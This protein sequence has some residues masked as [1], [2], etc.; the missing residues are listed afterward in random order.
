MKAKTEVY[1]LND[2][3]RVKYRVDKRKLGPCYY[4][5]FRGP[6]GRVHEVSTKETNR[7]RATDAALAIIDQ[8]YQ[9]KAYFEDIGWDDAV[10]MM[11]E[12]M[13]GSNLRPHTISTYRWVVEAFRKVFPGVPG[14]CSVTP[15]MAEEYK[16]KRLKAGLSPHTV[17][18]D[19]N[20]LGTVFGKWW[21]EVCKI[22]PV[23][24]FE[25]VEPPKADKLD[26]RIVA[27]FEREA[28][29]TW[30]VERWDNWRLPSLFLAVKAAIGC[31]VHELAAMPTCRLLDGRLTFDAVQAK[32]RRTRRSKLPTTLFEELQSVAGSTY[33]FERFPEELRALLIRKGR[34]HHARCVKFPFDPSRLVNWLQDRLVEFRK[35]RPDIARFK[36][37]NFRGTAMSRAKEAGVSYDEAAIAFGCHPE[38]MRRHY[39]KVDETAVSDGV[40]DRI[41]GGE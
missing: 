4:A 10:A 5:Y 33:V 2:G 13:K 40:M 32:G 6:D 23:N 16:M 39:V 18:G 20:E 31:R 34:P 28:F 17:K 41:Q 36:L 27:P 7:R 22:T 26:P 15:A 11:V 9:P 24:P 12:H 29:E 3:R 38:T 14:P 25:N 19:L 8:T 21:C 35:E 37:H 30:L 1:A